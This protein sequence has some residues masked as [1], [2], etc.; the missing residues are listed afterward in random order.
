MI[1]CD[2]CSIL[3]GSSEETVRVE[4]ILASRPFLELQEDYSDFWEQPALLFISAHAKD[5]RWKQVR[6]LHLYLGAAHGTALCPL[7][8]F[9]HILQSLVAGF[10]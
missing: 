8:C 9:T 7:K 2:F 1:F 6:F 3:W 5:N 10:F 4:V